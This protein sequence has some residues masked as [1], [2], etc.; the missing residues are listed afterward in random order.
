M[1][2]PATRCTPFRALPWLAKAIAVALCAAIAGFA[3]LLWPLWRD[4]DNL[5][6]GIFLPFLAAILFV[7]SRRD[8]SP[9]FLQPGAWPLAGGALL[10][11]AGLSSLAMAV[12][13]AAAL[14][15]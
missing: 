15:W 7:E 6:H 8:P 3:L 5:S 2:P 13:F 1:K 12:T 9:R 10:I 11:L 14:G 4:D